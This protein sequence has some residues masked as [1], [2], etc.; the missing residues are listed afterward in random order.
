MCTRLIQ[1]G[2]NA[3]KGINR[4]GA[5]WRCTSEKFRRAGGQISG[6]VQRSAGEQHA[7]VDG[8]T[9][10][11]CL[12]FGGV[13]SRT[14]ENRSGEFGRGHSIHGVDRSS[15]AQLSLIGIINYNNHVNGDNTFISAE[16]YCSKLYDNKLTSAYL[17]FKSM[18][19]PYKVWP[20]IDLKPIII[21]SLNSA[22]FILKS[23]IPVIRPKM[24]FILKTFGVHV[25]T[26]DSL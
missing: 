12:L 25:L 3:R 13:P 17:Q 16:L 18:S 19:A 24:H 10:R 6:R 15:L 7:T 2:S 21:V 22:L 8:V 4:I 26:E 14:G 9:T 20:I 5:C 1:D 11:L 23:S